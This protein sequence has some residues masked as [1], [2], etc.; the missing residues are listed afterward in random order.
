MTGF[1]VYI[2]SCDRITI[3]T[4]RFAPY[5]ATIPKLMQMLGFMLQPNLRAIALV[6]CQVLING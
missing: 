2:A 1:A 4:D 6:V 3:M 5:C